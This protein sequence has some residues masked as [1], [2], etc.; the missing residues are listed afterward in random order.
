MKGWIVLY[1]ITCVDMIVQINFLTM[2]LTMD[3]YDCTL[4][5]K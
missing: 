2:Q 1:V 4:L 5:K 3:R